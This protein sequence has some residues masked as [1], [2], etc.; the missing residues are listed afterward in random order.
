MRKRIISVLFA[1][2]FMLSLAAPAF[3]ETYSVAEA[4]AG[5]TEQGPDWFYVVRVDGGEWQ[6]LNHYA[7]WGD[8]WQYSTDPNGD[9]IYYSIFTWGGTVTL[10][11]GVKD[12][13]KYEVGVAFKAPGDGLIII[14]DFVVISHGGDPEAPPDGPVLLVFAVGDD[15]VA[16]EIDEYEMLV[17]GIVIEAEEG[18][19]VFIFVDPLEL[20]G[21]NVIIDNL[22]VEFEAA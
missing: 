8:N 19:L 3:A 4:Y 21:T 6:E 13:A 11:S 18:A 9:G 1:A 16:A 7:E 20:D 12:G 2:V 22:V 15:E 5:A 10:M 17:E 14:D